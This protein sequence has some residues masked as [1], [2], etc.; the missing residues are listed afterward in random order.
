M[1]LQDLT[2]VIESEEWAYLCIPNY[3]AIGA[4]EQSVPEGLVHEQT[5]SGRLD[6]IPPGE[7]IGLEVHE[8]VDQVLIFVKGEGRADLGGAT[9]DISPGDM[10][11]V[12]GRN[13]TWPHV[14]KASD[15]QIRQ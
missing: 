13:G 1:L 14:R 3:P 15:A 6:E 2:R 10:F 9:H 5:L 11:A 12:P 4:R 7:D 8:L